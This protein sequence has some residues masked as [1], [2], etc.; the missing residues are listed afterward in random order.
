DLL[1]ELSLL[2]EYYISS[3]EV[4]WKFMSEQKLP[5]WRAITDL[6]N[7]PWFQRVWVIQEVAVAPQVFVRYGG[8]S[9]CWQTFISTAQLVTSSNEILML[10]HSVQKG[11]CVRNDAMFGME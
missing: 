8:I 9:I 10:N 7:H 1:R 3:V 5:R 2:K 6:F 11:D 4:S